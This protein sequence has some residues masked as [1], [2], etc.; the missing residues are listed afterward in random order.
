M[1][2]LWKELDHY[3]Q[4]QNSVP[5]KTLRVQTQGVGMGVVVSGTRVGSI[6]SSDGTL[7]DP[8]LR[9]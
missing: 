5:Q 6:I 2:P 3:V 7:F 9:P 4:G 1:N 8:F